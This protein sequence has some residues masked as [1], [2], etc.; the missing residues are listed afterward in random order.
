[1]SRY[2]TRRERACRS[3]REGSRVR[4]IGARGWRAVGVIEGRCG[5]GCSRWLVHCESADGDW[6]TTRHHRASRL[7]PLGNAKQGGA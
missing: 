1:M 3:F 6:E 4:V 7:R 5:N 2:R